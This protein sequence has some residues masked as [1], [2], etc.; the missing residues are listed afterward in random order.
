M[1]NR[2]AIRRFRTI[3]ILVLAIP[4]FSFSQSEYQV[5]SI[6]NNIISLSSHNGFDALKKNSHFDINLESINS[7]DKSFSLLRF[8]AQINFLNYS[9]N[10]FNFSFL[11]YGTFQD[12]I[13]NEILNQ[14]T[15]YEVTAKLYFHSTIRNLFN[16]EYSVSGLYSKIENY[17]SSIITSDLKIH[18]QINNYNISFSLKNIGIILENYT[19]NSTEIPL[20]S[21]FSLIKSNKNN[22]SYFGY[23]MIYH[24]NFNNI[25]HII[26]FYTNISDNIN[27]MFSGSSYSK[28]LRLDDFNNDLLYGV[29]FGINIKNKY[30]KKI[31]MGISSLGSAGYIYGLTYNF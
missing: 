21:Q 5:I 1:G 16:I 30:N 4:T 28:Q 3:I 27:I 29:G 6:P 19:N 8:P 31:D 9:N 24:F 12:Q 22:T 26:C 23:D 7:N 14:F 15:S 2:R 10:N 11:D 13:D 18:N 25:E 17:T 20:K